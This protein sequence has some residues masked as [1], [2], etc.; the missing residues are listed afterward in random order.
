MTNQPNVANEQ[1]QPNV[2]AK[3]HQQTNVL[4]IEEQVEQ[5]LVVFILPAHQH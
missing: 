1:M 2:V 4:T 5:S 3:E